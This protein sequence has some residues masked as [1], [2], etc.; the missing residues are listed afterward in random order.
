MGRGRL[1]LAV[2]RPMQFAVMS[3]LLRLLVETQVPK[4]N[5]VHLLTMVM[6]QA[7]KLGR[8]ADMNALLMD[9]Q[10]KSSMEE[11]AEGMEQRSND[12]A[13]KDALTKLRKEEYASGMEQMSNDAAKLDVQS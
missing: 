5:D 1:Q 6:G 10:I 3:H 4:E 2:L 8:G 13:L 7:G 9:A 12:V 11:C